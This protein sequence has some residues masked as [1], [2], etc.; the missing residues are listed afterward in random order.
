MEQS[1]RLAELVL[2]SPRL[3]CDYFHV[4]KEGKGFQRWRAEL[5]DG[6]ELEVY[7]DQEQRWQSGVIDSWV[8]DDGSGNAPAIDRHFFLTW[9][10][11][12]GDWRY[13]LRGEQKVRMK[14]PT[15]EDL[16]ALPKWCEGYDYGFHP[17]EDSY[18][19]LPGSLYIY[20]SGYQAW[21][22]S[23]HVPKDVE[24]IAG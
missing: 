14:V 11:D 6:T 2:Q 24:L 23:K 7:L 4:Q 9:K 13:D 1:D 16:R 19:N 15:D 17:S 10:D 21:Y 22:C 18:C 8:I 5:I 20:P 3:D 12:Q